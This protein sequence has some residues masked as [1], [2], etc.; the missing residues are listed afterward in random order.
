LLIPSK[1]IV[2]SWRGPWKAGDADSILVVTITKA[3][4]GAGGSGA[5]WR[6]GTRLQGRQPGLAEVLLETVERISGETKT[7]VSATIG[8]MRFGMEGVGL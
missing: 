3:P 8:L 5:C 6:A 7:T 2:Q 4:G 1:M